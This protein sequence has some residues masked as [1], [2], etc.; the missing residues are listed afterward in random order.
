MVNS[1][2]KSH[3]NIAENPDDEEIK[4]KIEAAMIPQKYTAVKET[5]SQTMMKK[6]ITYARQNIFPK[7]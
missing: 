4:Q 2:I 6:Y 3:P 1:H 7:L 5:I